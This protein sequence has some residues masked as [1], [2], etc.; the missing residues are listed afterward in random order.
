[1]SNFPGSTMIPGVGLDHWQGV[2]CTSHGVHSLVEFLGI[3]EALLW[4]CGCAVIVDDR[5]LLRNGIC[6]TELARVSARPRGEPGR[7]ERDPRPFH[8]DFQDQI[9]PEFDAFE[10]KWLI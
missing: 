7:Q 8:L 2:I 6:A 10:R 5:A 1:M 9:P 4:R 3:L